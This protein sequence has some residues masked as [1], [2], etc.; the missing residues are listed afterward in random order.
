MEVSVPLPDRAP[1][2]PGPVVRWCGI[3]GVDS[4]RRGHRVSACIAL[5]FT[6]PLLQGQSGQDQGAEMAR[7]ERGQ[8]FHQ[9]L[10][11]HGGPARD[12][13]FFDQV[14]HMGFTAVSVSGDQNAAIPARHGLRF[15][16]DQIVGKGVLELRDHE[17]KKSWSAYQGSRDPADLVRPACLSD[18]ATFDRL[19]SELQD[20]LDPA[21]PHRPLAVSVGDEISSTRHANPL[22]FCFAPT[23]LIAFRKFLL[24][25][26]GMIE[27]V[28]QAWGTDFTRMEEVVPFTADRI[29]ARELRA[30]GLP[31]NLMPWSDHREFMD[32]RLAHAV[33]YVTDL[34]TRRAPGLRVGLTGIQPPSAYGGHDYARLLPMSTFFEA[35]DIG[36]A[37]DLAMSFA[38]ADALQMA[39]LFPPGEKRP[40]DF[41]RAR[42]HEFLA[43]GMGGVI[44]WSA[45]GAF[46]ASGHPSGFGRELATVFKELEGVKGA[47][48]GARIERSPVW[49]VESQASVRAHWMLDS[50]ADGDT[51]IRRLSSY[52]RSHSTSL[53]TRESWVLLLE[54][55]GLQGRFVASSGLGAKL[56]RSPPRLLV[57]P[58]Q[59][60]LSDEVAAAVRDYVRAGGVAVA[61]HGL[62]YYD[63]QLVLR[64]RPVLD[65]MFGLQRAGSWGRRRHVLQG[66]AMG[67][68]LRGGVGIA[69]GAIN[70]DLGEPA[71]GNV[72]Q[73]EHFHGRGQAFYL[74]LAVCEYVDMR[75]DPGRSEAATDLR[76]R[77]RHVLD[78]AGVRPPVMV[79]APGMPTCIERMMLRAVDGRRLLAIRMNALNDPAM[80]VAIGKRGSRSVELTFPKRVAIT[81]MLTGRSQSMN[82]QFEM[83]LDPWRALFLVL[84]DER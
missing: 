75:L 55:L 84:E 76:M 52:E 69:E 63:E 40:L 60:A 81:D 51:W 34:V 54:D 65:G 57:L 45:G 78:E 28:N 38:P 42:C 9:I 13:R 74:N 53:K 23:C 4:S 61:D 18:A 14:R 35:Y 46:G 82:H 11:L 32:E 27:E 39:T 10:W 83:E 6:V 67:P 20:K 62:G 7:E 8:S 16:R 22:D 33:E 79:R 70:A 58:A 5:L 48:S 1:F 15:Y 80:A 72:V 71:D 68:R 73:I 44:V 29:R 19:A 26:H 37:R 77:L 12:S 43:H 17:W 30:A 49:I 21:L 31:R 50:A 47:F 66:K 3:K 64:D 41:V 2:D 24:R 25:K 56:S 59:L 36:G